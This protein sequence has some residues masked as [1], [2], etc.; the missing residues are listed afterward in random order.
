VSDET[1]QKYDLIDRVYSTQNG[2][3][4]SP[5]R[6]ASRRRTL[7]NDISDLVTATY[8]IEEFLGGHLPFLDLSSGSGV[9]YFLET[10]SLN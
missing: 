2:F 3:F 8:R 5:N 9:Y 7:L 6:V 4:F 1:F 10:E